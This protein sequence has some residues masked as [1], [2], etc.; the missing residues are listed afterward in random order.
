MKVKI[1]NIE[2]Y[3]PKTKYSNEHFLKHFSDQGIDISGLL[4]VTGRKERYISDDYYENSLTM[5]I[6]ACEKVIRT[7]NIDVKDINSV[8]FVSTTPEYLAPTNAVKIH[9]ALGLT[10]NANAYDM[11]GNCAGMI[12]AMDQVCRTMKSNN[13]IKYSLL[14]GSDLLI[15]F[16]RRSEAIT[17]SNFGESAC[18]VLLENIEE[19]IEDN[20]S[21]FIDSSSYVDSSL[22]S[23]INFPPAGFSKVLP[24]DEDTSK[25]DRILEWI[26]FNTDEAFA[27]S[28][29]SINEIL[30]RNNL[31]KDDVKLYCLSQFA[32][33]NIDMIRE[34]LEEPAHKFPFVGDKFGYTAV[35]SPFMALADSISQGKLNRGDYVILWT[36][37]AGVV[38]SCVLIRY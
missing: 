30:G 4:K 14:V 9:E 11:N 27:S 13:R 21:D 6:E 8:V 1:K 10:K 17:Y 16:S 12:I 15:R 18:A 29:D 34:S 33:K 25:D 32:K 31:T 28:V 5:A 20:V 7:A 19:N 24:I 37:G 3:T 2:Y 38:A 36:V 22:S 26:N 23:C 35:T